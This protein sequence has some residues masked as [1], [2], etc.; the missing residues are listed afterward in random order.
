MMGEVGRV[1]GNREVGSRERKVQE[2]KVAVE[3]QPSSDPQTGFDAQAR[4]AVRGGEGQCEANVAYLLGTPSGQRA[5]VHGQVDAIRVWTRRIASP[6]LGHIGL[7][8]P[9]PLSAIQD[10]DEKRTRSSCRVVQERGQ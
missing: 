4:R 6:F 1:K 10:I 3:S 9:T 5:E 2:W 7:D 8:R